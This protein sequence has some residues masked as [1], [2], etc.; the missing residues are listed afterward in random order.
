MKSLEEIRT[1]YLLPLRELMF[2]AAEVQRAGR[3]NDDI[4]RC[5]LLSIKTGGCSER[6]HLLQL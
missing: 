4:Q 5:S 1:T 3:N 2:R 6:L